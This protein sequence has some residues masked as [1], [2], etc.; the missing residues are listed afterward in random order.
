MAKAKAKETV[1][2]AMASVERGQCKECESYS[3]DTSYCRC[4]DVVDEL[5]KPALLKHSRLTKLSS[6]KMKS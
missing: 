2:D 6:W 5:I 4:D 3:K 1:I